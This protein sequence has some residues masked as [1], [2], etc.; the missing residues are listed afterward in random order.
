MPLDDLWALSGADTETPTVAAAWRRLRV[1]GAAPAGRYE[2]A[3]AVVVDVEADAAHA[4]GAAG[5][6]TLKPEA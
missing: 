6:V 4:A 2:H 3:A 5:A 1:K